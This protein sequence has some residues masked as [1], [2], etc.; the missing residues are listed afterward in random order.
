MGTHL[1]LLK[2]NGARSCAFNYE[3]KDLQFDPGEF[4]T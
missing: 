1:L 2:Y 4:H 3:V